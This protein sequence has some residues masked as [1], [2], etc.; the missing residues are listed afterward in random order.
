MSIQPLRDF[1]LVTK[2]AVPETSPGSIIIRPGNVDE[3]LIKALVV[4]VGSGRVT[5]DGTTIPL[6]V[7]VGDRVVFN[8]TLATELT[9]GEEKALIL[10]EDQILCVLK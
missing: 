10:R 6:E 8:R 1:V 2:E 5:N 7:K 3:K 4:A 9:D